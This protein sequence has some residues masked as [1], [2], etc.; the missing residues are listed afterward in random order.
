M[1]ERWK[2]KA[3]VTRCVR[4][5]KRRSAREIDVRAR[6]NVDRQERSMRQLA[7]ALKCCPTGPQHQCKD[8]RRQAPAPPQQTARADAADRKGERARERWHKAAQQKWP[9]QPRYRPGTAHAQERSPAGKMGAKGTFS[10]DHDRTQ[11]LSGW[12]VAF[13]QRSRTASPGAPSADSKSGRC[14]SKRRARKR[15]MA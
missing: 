15:A 5:I 4:V 8:R 1:L 13:V 6:S 10:A 11:T 2:R 3:P 7:I 14:G 9:L 12:A